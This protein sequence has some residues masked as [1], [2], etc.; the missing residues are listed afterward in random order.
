MTTYFP[1]A[2]LALSLIIVIWD[3]VLAGRIAQLRLA[4][5]PFCT[6]TGL[7]GLMLL[8]ALILHMAMSTF[9]TGRA[10]LAVDWIWPLIVTLFAVQAIYAV[11]RRLVNYLWGVPIVVYDV[12]L[13]V[14]E[15]IR[16]GVAHG[17]GWANGMGGVLTAQSS[18]L[19]IVTQSSV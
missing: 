15:I 5:R 18:T 8:P 14:T 19:A 6:I 11:S 9:I 3:V 16:Y 10:V 1:A 4:S 12:V 13:A 17:W 2:H 7:C